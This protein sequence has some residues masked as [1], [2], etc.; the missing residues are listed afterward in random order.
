MQLGGDSCPLLG[1][2][3]TLSYH[4]GKTQLETEKAMKSCRNCEN[5]RHDGYFHVRLICGLTR[6]VIVPFSKALD[7]NQQADAHAR[8]MANHCADYIPE[9]QS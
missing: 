8:H 5:A 1:V 9:G 3:H 4:V 2:Y 7:E 6:R